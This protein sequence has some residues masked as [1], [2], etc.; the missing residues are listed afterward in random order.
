M[1]ISE[2]PVAA[3]E[4]SPGERRAW[5]IFQ[6]PL[7]LVAYLFLLVF[8]ALFLFGVAAAQTT[9]RPFDI[10]LLLVLVS[11]AVMCVA[12][13]NRI[14]MPSGVSRDLLGA[15][16]FPAMLLL[17]PVY[18]LLIPLPVYLLLRRRRSHT[19]PHRLV[20]NAAVVGVSGC[21]ASVVWHGSQAGFPAGISGSPDAR[22][23]LFSV[24]GVALALACCAGFT[25][26]NSLLVFLGSRLGGATGSIRDL[27]DREGCLVDSAELCV[28][29]TVAILAQLSLFLLDDGT[30]RKLGGL[31]T[32]RPKSRICPRSGRMSPAMSRRSTVLPEPLPPMTTSVSP[33]TAS[34]ESPRST[35]VAS[36]LF[37][38]STTS[39]TAPTPLTRTGSAGAW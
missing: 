4:S 28:G 1:S 38:T 7:G 5:L 13:V 30:R 2:K 24:S 6:Q 36:K 21:L 8:V 29:V 31:M 37:R 23:A 22:E 12:A 19:M 39:M 34:S 11:S 27:W 18:S 35:W 3:D 14:D 16:W 17:P 10:V 26:L 20:F 25:V 32:S 15:W 33:A 9:L